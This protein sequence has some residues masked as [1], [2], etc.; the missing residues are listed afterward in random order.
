MVGR[1]GYGFRI[2]GERGGA[3]K[4]ALSLTEVELPCGLC[5]DVNGQLGLADGGIELQWT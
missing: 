3:G 4:Y 2:P 5:D 1:Q